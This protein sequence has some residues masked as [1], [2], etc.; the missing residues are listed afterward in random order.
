MRERERKRKISNIPNHEYHVFFI[1]SHYGV[2]ASEYERLLY[3][4]IY[5]SR[6][7]ASLALAIYVVIVFV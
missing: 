2:G 7:L 1:V 6:I 3:E 5:L 4:E